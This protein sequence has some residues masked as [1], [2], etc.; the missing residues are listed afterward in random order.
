[1]LSNTAPSLAKNLKQRQLLAAEKGA[2]M[3]SFA[4]TIRNL[5]YRV[6]LL[7]TMLTLL[8]ALAYADTLTVTT[9]KATYIKGEVMKVTAVFKD[10]YGK[11]ITGA[12]TREVRIKNPSG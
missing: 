8:P 4:C 11:P 2:K 12:N 10:K 1:V 9:N 7:F 6:I 5:K 3:T